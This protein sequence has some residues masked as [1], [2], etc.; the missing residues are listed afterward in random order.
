M[1]VTLDTSVLADLFLPVEEGRKVKRNML[2]CELFRKRFELK[3]LLVYRPLRQ[4]QLLRG[5]Y[6]QT[7]DEDRICRNVV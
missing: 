4:F 2:F 6:C 3:F 1:A 5:F 7:I